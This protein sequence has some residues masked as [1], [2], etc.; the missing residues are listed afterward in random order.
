FIDGLAGRGGPMGLAAITTL[1]RYLGQPQEE[2]RIIH[3]AGTNGKG[4]VL[5]YLSS[6]LEEAG[7]RAGRYI[8]P[9]LFSYRERIQINGEHISRDDFAEVM[10]EIA[11]AMDR[12]RAG[13]QELP[14]AFEAETAAAF[15][16]FKR[17]HCDFVLLEAGMGGLTDATNVIRKPLLTALASISMDHM[18]ELGNTL[19]EI[20]W[21]KA[22]IFKEGVPVVSAAQE[23][24]AVEVI[25]NEARKK[26]CSCTFVQR[27]QILPAGEE[28]AEDQVFSY[29]AFGTIEIHLAGRHQGKCCACAGMY[30]SFTAGGF[31]DTGA[32]GEG[33]YVK[34]KLE[35]SFHD[36]TQRTICSPGRCA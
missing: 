4:S 26:H 16:Y 15:L 13:G 22:G 19:R 24:E 35:R 3:I 30:W 29:G 32:R 17:Q 25:Q 12:M 1:L 34:N 21:N 11:A 20:A 2:L 36:H 6:V 23:E 33:R 18:R 28:Q 9:T 14:S 8:S 7:Y 5:A 31:R 27:E 10:T